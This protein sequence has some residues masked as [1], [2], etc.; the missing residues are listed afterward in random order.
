MKYTKV[1]KFVD[2]RPDEKKTGML[3]DKP[4]KID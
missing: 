4:K 2:N 1:G 3:V